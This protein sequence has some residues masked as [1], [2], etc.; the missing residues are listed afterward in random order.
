MLLLP[1]IWAAV[2]ARVASQSPGSSWRKP[3][4]TT[5]RENRIALAQRAI[6]QAVSQFNGTNSM[7]PDPSNTYGL[8]G[9]VY[10][11]LAEFDQLTTQSKYA[12]DL[13]RYYSS[14]K[15]ALEQSGTKNFS[16]FYVLNFGLNFGHGAIV[17]YKAYNE[18]VFL[19]Y[20]IQS[21]WAAV[22][23]TITQA[24]LNLGAMASKSFDLSPSCQ[25]ATMA[26]GAFWSKDLENPEIVVIATGCVIP[27]LYNVTAYV[28]DSG[29][30]I[31]SALLAEATSNVLYLSAAI[32]SMSFIRSHLYN[33]QGLVL[34]GI[35]ARA[36]DSC[37]IGG[38]LMS[39][40]SGLMIEGLAV[41]YSVSK[42]TS[43]INML[44]ELISASF[45][46]TSWQ[47]STG[48]IQP[49]DGSI[50]RGL[51]AAYLRNAT[52]PSVRLS[53]ASYLAVQYNAV[54]DLAKQNGGDVY[55]GDWH[56]PAGVTFDTSSQINAI[57]A[58]ISSIALDEPVLSS[59]PSASNFSFLSSSPTATASAPPSPS[60]KA[61]TSIG[62]LVGGIIA[63][64]A[65]LA[66]LLALLLCWRWKQ[67]QS[68][69]QM[70]SLVS[71]HPVVG[72]VDAFTS[73]HPSSHSA[74][75]TASSRSASESRNPKRADNLGIP[76]RGAPLRSLSSSESWA[77]PPPTLISE[78]T[79][80]SSGLPP[81]P[82]KRH[83]PNVAVS[84][85]REDPEVANEELPEYRAA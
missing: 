26:G 65:V 43:Y 49:G 80:S 15:T 51:T 39:Y 57:Q 9:A 63:G 78:T 34:D 25:G 82:L 75:Q 36:N 7:F 19:D 44:D 73:F 72:M 42:N 47:N 85:T 76:V 53:I 77:V 56:G 31:L 4:L 28:D 66:L 8:T 12:D 10:S 50:P 81:L 33:A 16:G 64:V 18:P 22:P 59:S 55:G 6:S 37:A 20:A 62:G 13:G 54:V 11:Q 60:P 48:I 14:A 40:N 38:G 84:P 70:A 24:E 71:P 1:F 83:V 29:F 35:S 46:T 41:L 69:L 23:Y 5:S 30:F 67:R 32:E 45:A 61:K 2:V 79:R 68:R 58:L 27:S 21:W 3:N 17:A 52:S 74:S